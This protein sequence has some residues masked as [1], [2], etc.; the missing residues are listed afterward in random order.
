MFE[1][2]VVKEYSLR[3]VPE[4][5]IYTDVLKFKDMFFQKFGNA[6]YLRSKPH[7]T[8]AKFLMNASLENKLAKGLQDLVSRHSSFQLNTN[9]FIEFR[10]ANALV[11]LIEQNNVLT[12][13]HQDLKHYLK[14]ELRL[15]SKNRQVTEVP[16][17][18]IAKANDYETLKVWKN[19]F[20]NEIH[21][22]QFAVN[23]F[24][25]VCRVHSPENRATPWE[26]KSWEFRLS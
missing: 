5:P 11:I 20:E 7:S 1:E 19:F 8:T 15:K 14:N 9:N 2:E 10:G 26:E 6:T 23:K 18:T 21:Q 4:K 13:I 17:F 3:I 25:L 22:K 16:H 12:Q 24:S